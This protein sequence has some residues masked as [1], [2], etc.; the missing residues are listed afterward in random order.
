MDQNSDQ[1]LAAGQ[2]CHDFMNGNHKCC[3]SERWHKLHKKMYKRVTVGFTRALKTILDVLPTFLSFSVL[4]SRY[5]Y[6]RIV[7]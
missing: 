7:I 2:R 3:K 4:F 1:M 5:E 6:Y